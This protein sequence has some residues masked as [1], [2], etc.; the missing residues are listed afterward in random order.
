MVERSRAH[1]G[2]WRRALL[3]L[4][5]LVAVAASAAAAPAANAPVEVTFVKTLVDPGTRYYA[6]TTGDGGTIEMWVSNSS[7][8]GSMQH[9]DVTLRAS[10]SGGRTFT[11]MLKGTFNF[12]TARTLLSGVVTDGWLAGAQVREQGA[13]VNDNPLT[14]EG[15]LSLM[16]ASA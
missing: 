5:A 2:G 10:L 6:G 9:F 7:V 15:T 14:F 1:R 3:L 12:S 8:S 11:A 4:V 13:L 16:P